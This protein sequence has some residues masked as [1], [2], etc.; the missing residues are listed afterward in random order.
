MIGDRD[1]DVM[2]ARENGIDVAAVL[3]GYGSREETAGATYQ[4]ATVD[5]LRA[6]LL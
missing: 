6:F 1:M 2:G 5:E 4:L 3:Y